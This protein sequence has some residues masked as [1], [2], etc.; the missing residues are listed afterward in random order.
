M[1]TVQ[2]TDPAYPVVSFV[3]VISDDPR[4]KVIR[5]VCHVKWPNILNGSSDVLLS[6][7]EEM[8]DDHRNCY[9]FLKLPELPPNLLMWAAR[10][11]ADHPIR[12]RP[13]MWSVT[14]H[15]SDKYDV[16]I[17]AIP[18]TDYCGGYKVY[19]NRSK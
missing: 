18:T 17:V 16:L 15:N 14:A 13:E 8:G 6:G 4:L 12:T 7:T 19:T 2:E 9:L 11:P 3:S 1:V 10:L 5:V